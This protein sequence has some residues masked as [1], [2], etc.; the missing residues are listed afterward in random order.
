MAGNILL[1]EDDP[2]NRRNLVTFFRGHGYSIEAS[3]NGPAAVER[4][5]A[6][7]FDA[8]IADFQLGGTIDGVEVLT[9]FER[10]SPGKGKI[11]ISGA[12]GLEA[13]CASLGALFVAKPFSLTDLLFKLQSVLPKT[14]ESIERRT[15]NL[16]QAIIK[17]PCRERAAIV[18][19]RARELRIICQ[20]RRARSL[21]L[22][23]HSRELQARANEL[24]L[25]HG[26]A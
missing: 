21:E 10:L 1:V 23:Q 14:P 22:L 13:Y 24:W 4:I 6:F 26:P 20:Q 19:Q 7:S 17:N 9:H 25:G 18:K 5:R 2:R 8:V 15:E 12:T 11:L 16:I 3:D